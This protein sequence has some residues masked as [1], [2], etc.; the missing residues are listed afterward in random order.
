MME[1]KIIKTI[2]HVLPSFGLTMMVSIIVV[3]DN[4]HTLVFVIH[5]ISKV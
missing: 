5:V 2:Y 4:R 1:D 3:L